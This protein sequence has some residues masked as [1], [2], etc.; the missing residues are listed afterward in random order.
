MKFTSENIRTLA[1]YIHKYIHRSFRHHYEP[2]AC[3][4]CLDLG[5]LTERS[6]SPTHWLVQ[7]DAG[8]PAD[9]HTDKLVS[10][11]PSHF[12]VP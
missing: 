11:A 5:F 4:I 9:A 10:Q 7:L 1:L 3:P 8:S 12:W 6:A 2:S